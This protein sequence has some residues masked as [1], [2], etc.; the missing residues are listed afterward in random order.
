MADTTAP[1]VQITDNLP[2]IANRATASVLYTLAFSEDVTGLDASDLSVFNGTV[3]GV[4]GSGSVWTV[5][6]TP[7]QGVSNGVIG[8]TLKA[9]GVVDLAGNL[10]PVATNTSQNLDT[11]APA[12]PK[13]VTNA[14]FNS[15]V[16]PQ[17][18]F[19]TT[20]GAV[21]F[22]LNPD[23]APV[24]VANMLAYV[25]TGFY[26]GTLFHRVMPTGV[27]VVQGGGFNSG[28]VYK[29]PTYGPIVLESGNGLLNLRGTLAMARTSVADSATSQFYVNVADN[30]FLNYASP[31]APGYAVF[32]KV[33]A[34]M[35]VIDTMAQVPTTTILPY[36]NVPVTEVTTL[37]ARQTLAGSTFSNT[38][39]LTVSGLEVGAQWAYS[40]D[41][42]VHWV[43]GA[44]NSLAVPVGR[45]SPVA[46]RV[47]QMDAAGN[48]SL[49]D[50]VF[51]SALV[52][53]TTPPVIAGLNPADAA[54][55]VPVGSDITVTFSEAIERGNGTI[56]L[57]TAAGATVATFS[58]GSPELTVSGTTLTIH[59]PAD[60]AH[61]TR[62]VLEIA[63]GA[64]QDL[65]G[66]AFA[67]TTRYA[68]TTAGVTGGLTGTNADDQLQGTAGN[69]TLTPGLGHDTVNAGAGVDTVILPLFPN[70]YRLTESSPGHVS[71]SYAAATLHLNDVELVQFGRAPIPEDAER[72][73]TTIA[74]SQLV[75]GE[76]QLQLGRLTDL[77]L[78]FFGRAPD[79]SGLEYW[80]E[81]LLE[82]GRD[83]ATI[84]KDFAWS[85]EA[86]ALFPPAASN[87][88]FVRTVYLNCFGREPD[89]GGWDFWTGKLDGLTDLNDRGAFVGEV[90]L[91]AYASTSGEE[92][93]SLLTNRHEAAM[94]YVNK[95]AADPAEGF[96]AAINTLLARVTGVTVTEDKAEDVINYAFA[97]PVT[98]AGIMTDQPLLDSIWGA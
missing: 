10:N 16:D 76:A 13:L 56:V 86:Q 46:I 2:G 65:A 31:G 50:G 38:G 41:G 49:L 78:A 28:L 9:G 67:G 73:Q 64:L 91:G 5:R 71:G 36:A 54:T 34:G 45:Y 53:E 3:A 81:K 19:Q 77:Y 90:I 43:L 63:P 72:F 32:G 21:V 97:N 55:A 18:T 69:D 80:Q 48:V 39:L 44:G 14:S 94:Y 11:A 98:L 70:V 26:D 59:P 96:D 74:L 52:V 12:A 66:N 6:V 40:L 24:T 62:Y 87:R 30:T 7:L 42:G 92:D 47:A 8:L 61:G 95:L 23:L 82:E 20:L 83:F 75:S 35:A 85:A 84:S 79:V 93:R 17:V 51:F 25:N 22:E 68:F 33:V 27:D 4:T 15:V 57:K 88:E 29:V 1:T 89:Q 60:L 58:P 37:T